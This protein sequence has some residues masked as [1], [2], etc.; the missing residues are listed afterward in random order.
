MTLSLADKRGIA[1]V[2]KLSEIANIYATGLDQL[3]PK[4]R[5]VALLITV[6]RIVV[7]HIVARYTAM[8]NLL[9]EII[10]FYFFGQKAVRRKQG[11]QR[12]K[13]LRIFRHHVL[14]ET[15]L[16]K[17]MQIIHEIQ[18]V[19][20]KISEHIRKLNAIR[21]AVTHSSNP[22]YRKEYRKT[23]KVA[24][25]KRD[26][27]TPQGLSLFETDSLAALRALEPRIPGHR[28][29]RARVTRKILKKHDIGRDALE[30]IP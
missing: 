6:Q 2:E 9:N 24:Y 10:I 21:N 28:S 4:V 1:K 8:D 29:W 17:K 18:P 25:S 19:P 22:E 30:L 16:L 3:H 27:F 7:A 20:A 26:I 5:A 13:K 12:S 11:D 14:D 15:Y 23:K